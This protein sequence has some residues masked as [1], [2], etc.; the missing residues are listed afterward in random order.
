MPTTTAAQNLVHFDQVFKTNRFQKFDHG[1]EEKNLIK[2]GSP[3][4]PEYDLKGITHP[5]IYLIYGLNDFYMSEDGVEMLK[6]DLKNAREFYQ[7]SDPKANHMDPIIG[8][9]TAVEVN[10]KVIGILSGYP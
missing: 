3:K 6:A 10:Q 9:N 8:I 2:Y 5:N 4:P 7:L 1:S